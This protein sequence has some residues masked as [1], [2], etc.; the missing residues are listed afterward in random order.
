[1]FKKNNRFKQR[2]L[3]FFCLIL[4]KKYTILTLHKSLNFNVSLEKN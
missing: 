4:N 2:Q 3:E 1:M